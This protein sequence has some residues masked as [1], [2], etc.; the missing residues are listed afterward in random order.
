[1]KNWFKLFLC[2]SISCLY[3]FNYNTTYLSFIVVFLFLFLYIKEYIKCNNTGFTLLQL[4]ILSL[5]FSFYSIIGDRYF[6]M[7]I[8]LQF[9]LIFALI[10]SIFRGRVNEDSNISIL[11]L[12][13]GLLILFIF[14]YYQSFYYNYTFD[15]FVK[16]M[17]FILSLYVILKSIDLSKGQIIYLIQLFVGVSFI[18]G[19]MVL[20][21]FLA[22]RFYGINDLGLQIEYV[23]RIGL[24]G[25]FYDFSIMSV[26]MSGLSIILVI[27]FF[28]KEPI[29]NSK[30]D[31]ILSLFFLCI[32]VLTSARSGIAAFFVTLCLFFI[33]ERK[34]KAFIVSLFL[35]IPVGSMVYYVFSLSE[36]SFDLNDTGR[37]DNYNNA[38]DYFIANPFFGAKML[39]YTELTKNMRPH[40]FIIDFLVEYGV[41]I[42]TLLLILLAFFIVRGFKFYPIL[43]YLLLAFLIGGLFHSSFINTHYIMIPI[44]LIASYKNNKSITNGK[45]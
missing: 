21:Q 18:S 20:V 23:A 7:F 16:I 24:A 19:I 15:S 2:G 28:K 30:I 45:F 36:R 25:L 32:S 22:F 33:I 17:I 38:L 3:L 42:T 26:F 9:S 41:I 6:S 43:S 1:M 40:N 34:T 12:I 27:S 31:I 44:Y 8:L 13:L 10:N 35:A 4:I 39:G 11:L 5:P 37:W 14:L 29:F